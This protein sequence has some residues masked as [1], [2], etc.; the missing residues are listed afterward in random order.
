VFVQ[1][2]IPTQWRQLSQVDFS[3]G[4]SYSL[5]QE[6]NYND[7]DFCMVEEESTSG[8]VYVNLIKNPERFTGYAGHQAA[9]VWAAIYEENCF[10]AQHTSPLLLDGFE[11]KEKRVFYKIVSGK[12]RLP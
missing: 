11:C 5:F 1:D 8:G 3:K 10:T 9:R 7:K 4:K 6:C 12:K 2:E